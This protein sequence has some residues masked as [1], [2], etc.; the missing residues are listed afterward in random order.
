MISNHGGKKMWCIAGELDSEYV[1]RMEDILD[2]YNRPYNRAEPVICF[3]EKPVMLHKDVRPVEAARPGRLMRRDYEYRRGGSVNVFCAIEPL[4]GRC[5]VRPTGKRT[6]REYAKMI[7]HIARC[8]PKAKTIHLVQD[9][10]NIHVAKSLKDLYGQRQG[11]RIW[12]RFTVHYT[13]KHASWLNQAE[14]LIG[15]FSR[16]CLGKARIPSLEHLQVLARS[17]ARAVRCRPRPIHWSF[18]SKDARERFRY[19]RR[20]R[21]VLFTR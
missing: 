4:T 7:A 8:F 17:W 12:S 13:P 5:F 16:Q 20:R 15:K 9:N 3:D 6:A 2:L 21:G 19:R 10:L 11:E 1:H 14:I 18:T